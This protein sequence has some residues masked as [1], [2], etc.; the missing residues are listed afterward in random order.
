MEIILR[1]NKKYS[2]ISANETQLSL[3]V[4]LYEIPKIIED[5]K[6]DNISQATIKDHDTLEKL[7]YLVLDG[8]SAKKENEK[9]NLLVFFKPI[10]KET[11]ELK[12]NQEEIKAIKKII[13]LGLN[14]SSISDVIKW[15]KFLNDWKV[16]VYYKEGERFKYN[17]TAFEAVT[18]VVADSKNTPGKNNKLYKK[19]IKEKID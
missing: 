2:L 7:G 19:L 16:G 5:M 3:L 18:G 15:T 13:A 12:Q 10:S 1:N 14:Q 4:N 8:F 17:G 6:D 11:I 9:Y